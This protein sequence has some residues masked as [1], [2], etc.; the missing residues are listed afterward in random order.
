LVALLPIRKRDCDLAHS[1]GE[2][3]IKARN[4]VGSVSLGIGDHYLERGSKQ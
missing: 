4:E 2:N 1:D 3:E